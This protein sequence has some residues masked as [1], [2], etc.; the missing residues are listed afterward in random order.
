MNYTCTVKKDLPIEGTIVIVST[1]MHSTETVIK[2]TDLVKEILVKELV[3][4]L[5][6]NDLVEF[7]RISQPE[8]NTDKIFARVCLVPRNTIQFLRK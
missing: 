6:K 5:I 1:D 8:L 3:Y 7:T 2:H 4:E